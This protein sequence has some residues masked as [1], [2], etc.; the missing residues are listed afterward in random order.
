MIDATNRHLRERSASSWNTYVGAARIREIVAWTIALVATLT[1]FVAIALAS[2][3]AGTIS[4]VTQINQVD[5]YGQLLDTK[6]A[7]RRAP[8]DT[9]AHAL[10]DR[11]VLDAFEVADSHFLMQANTSIAQ[12]L[13]CSPTARAQIITYWQQSSPL[14]IDGSWTKPTMETSVALTSFLARPKGEYLAQWTTQN[15]YPTGERTPTV[16]WQGDFVLEPGGTVSDDNVAGLCISHLAFSE[17][18]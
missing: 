17:V 6:A 4:W 1:A 14:G 5:R 12:G 8:M 9:L 3:Y 15:I 13:L 7:M 16:L 11:F 2:H 10:V 18:K